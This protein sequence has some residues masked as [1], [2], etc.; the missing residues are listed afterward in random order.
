MG[1][2]E[3][4]GG[5]LVPR[6]AR[7]P[8]V[9][10]KIV[11]SGDH[12]AMKPARFIPLLAVIAVA[13]CAVSPPEYDANAD[14]AVR[15]KD[16]GDRYVACMSVEAEKQIGNPAGADEI[17][18]AAHGRCWTE[19]EGYRNATNLSFVEGAKSRDERQ[20]ARDKAEAHLRQFERESRSTV[21][22]L[23]VNRTLGGQKP[24]P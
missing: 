1:V 6:Q 16:A 7:Q 3:L 10:Y 20:L 19:W 4:S 13:G 14:H 18:L 22:D 5:G 2:A 24:Q 15:M 12:R 11:F 9:P 8:I 17:A 21:V 23:V